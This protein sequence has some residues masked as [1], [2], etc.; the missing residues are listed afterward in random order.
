[1]FILPAFIIK[2]LSP[3]FFTTQLQNCKF[4]TNV[5]V[6]AYM[7]KITSWSIDN[8]VITLIVLDFYLFLFFLLV[9]DFSFHYE[10][11][12]LIP[13][14]NNK[15][16]HVNRNALFFDNVCHCVHIYSVIEGSPFKY[17]YSPF[18]KG[19]PHVNTI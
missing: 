7:I 19:Q 5:L 2:Q 4:Y 6:A 16:N 3:H 13:P 18:S 1:M 9:N 14:M 10:C 17:L 15:M 8:M 12:A 11:G